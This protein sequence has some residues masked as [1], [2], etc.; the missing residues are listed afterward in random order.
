MTT[1]CA[2]STRP[3]PHSGSTDDP[4][5]TRV[6]QTTPSSEKDA[7]MLTRER[8]GPRWN[9]VRQ[10]L[11]KT[12]GGLI[13]LRTI[14][15]GSGRG[16]LSV[17]LAEEGAEVTLLDA[18]AAA[19]ESAARRFAGLGLRARF[20]QDDLREVGVTTLPSF[21]VA[22][23]IGVIEHFSG[24]QRTRVLRAH[25]DTIHRHGLAVVSVPHSWCLPYRIWKTYLEWRRW[26]PYGPEFPY[27]RSELSRRAREAGFSGVQLRAFG[28]LHSLGEH[29][30]K[31]LRGQRPSWTDAPSAW[32]PLLG[33]SLVMIAR[34]EHAS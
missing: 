2:A 24:P 12:F 1:T 33:L 20:V 7:R 11:H 3:G 34:K 8:R 10:E 26:W 25:Y 28:L 31:R 32:D 29:W 21:D 19:L 17:L 27:S 23:S 5:W 30:V 13:G 14:E 22:L 16:D 9:W 4:V 15:L 6:W 18:N